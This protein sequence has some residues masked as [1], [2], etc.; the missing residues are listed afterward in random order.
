MAKILIA[1]SAVAVVDPPSRYAVTNVIR[2]YREDISDF[3]R[4]RALNFVANTNGS[5]NSKWLNVY[6]ELVAEFQMDYSFNLFTDQFYTVNAGRRYRRQ[7]SHLEREGFV[8]NLRVERVL[9]DY[10]TLLRRNGYYLVIVDD[11]EGQVEW[12]DEIILNHF[13][14][15]WRRVGSLTV[16]AIYKRILWLYHPFRLENGTHGSLVPFQRKTNFKKE[17]LANM[18]QYPLVVEI[19]E[20]GYNIAVNRLVNG[21]S[22]FDHFTGPDGVTVDILEAKMNFTAVLQPPDKGDAFGSKL[23][24]GTFTGTLGHIIAQKSDLAL[25]GFFIKDYLTRDIEFTSA[26]YGDELCLLSKKASRIPQYILP[27]ICFELDLWICLLITIIFTTFFWAF[28]RHLN[29]KIIR[30]G[31]LHWREF[32]QIGVDTV[33]LIL[34]SPMR[35]FPTINSERSF[36]ASICLISLVFVSIFQSSLSTVFIKPIFYKDIMNFEDLAAA[37]LPIYVKY[38]AMMDDMFPENST[39][40]LGQMRAQMKLISSTKSLLAAISETGKFVGVTR[41]CT[42][43]QDNSFYFSSRQLHLIPQCPRIYN[44]AYLGPRHSVYLKRVNEILLQLNNG[45]LHEKWIRDMNYKFALQTRM[46]YGSFHEDAF[47]VF[48]MTDLQLPFFILLFGFGASTAAFIFERL[49]HIKE[50]ELR[51][52]NGNY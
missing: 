45:G 19:F 36:V 13:R 5:T 21:V 22:V 6:E 32:L 7:L 29:A 2:T 34:S 25:T 43:Y 42:V 28:L 20:S 52:V 8:F 10:G 24:N 18:N 3:F 16:M 14:E 15:I 35:K 46:K 31:R 1:F 11:A 41:R 26:I 12:G 17:L 39:G 9:M 44:L 47:K 27:L 37:K 4:V 51:A 23:P 40:I 38:A 49:Y 48:T 30:G 50:E 33:M